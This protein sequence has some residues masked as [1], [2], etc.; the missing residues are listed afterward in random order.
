MLVSTLC[1]VVAV[2][3]GSC[4]DVV[5]ED[6]DVTYARRKGERSDHEREKSSAAH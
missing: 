2:H 5:R 1:I 6:A 3:R 4:V